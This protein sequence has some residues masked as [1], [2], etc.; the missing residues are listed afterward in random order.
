LDYEES[1]REYYERF[2]ADYDAIVAHS[3]DYTAHLRLP[4]WLLQLLPKKARLLDLGCGTGLSSLPYLQAGHSVIGLDLSKEMLTKARALP[5]ENLLLGSFSQPLPL[6]DAQFDAVQ[7]LGAMDFVTDLV[8]LFNEIARVLKEGGYFLVTLPLPLSAE[9]EAKL[10]I[11]T[12][13]PLLCERTLK[14][15]GFV[16]ARKE[17]L[18]GFIYEEAN[19]EYRSYLWRKEKA[20][21]SASV[22]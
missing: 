17:Q 7:I 12:H 10:Q 6:N 13:D 9:M 18:P 14:E 21:P 4:P 22:I 8:R 20:L 15:K 1:V 16:C 2:A 5:F 3:G 19:V 11:R